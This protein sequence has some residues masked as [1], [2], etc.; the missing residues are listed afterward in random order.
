MATAAVE[1]VFAEIEQLAPEQQ[2]EFFEQLG[3]RRN[4]ASP[5][6]EQA[7]PKCVPTGSAARGNPLHR[8]RS[9]EFAWLEQHRAEYL[10]QWVALEGD[11]LLYHTPDLKELF[12]EANQGDFRDALM[13]LI[14][15]AEGPYYH[16]TGKGDRTVAI[17]WPRKDRSR[18]Q[19]WLKQ[20]RHEY[21]GEWLALDGDRLISHSPVLREVTAEMKKQDV[22]SPYLIRVDS[23]EDLPW[24][25]F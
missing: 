12:R 1:R 23:P 18:E 14:E 22:Q 21:A 15:T 5:A 24:A 20:H 16:Q 6:V 17:N 10:G 9:R 2:R 19:A 13:V 4:G 3:K 8:D 7:N 11:Q 25:G